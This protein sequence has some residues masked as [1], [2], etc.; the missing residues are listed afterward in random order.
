MSSDPFYTTA[1]HTSK[2]SNGYAEFCARN[3]AKDR[4]Y[5][6]LSAQRRVIPTRA[7]KEFD[8]MHNTGGLRFSERTPNP[9]RA[10]R[11]ELRKKVG[12]DHLKKWGTKPV[13][14]EGKTIE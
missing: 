9:H 8:L 14:E 12:E 5:D 4:F 13:D 3:R 11:L 1:S 10:A 7:E 6:G 2:S